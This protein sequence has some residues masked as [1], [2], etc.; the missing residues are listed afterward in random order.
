MRTARGVG[1]CGRHMGVPCSMRIFTSSFS[2]MAPPGWG[3][4]LVGGSFAGAFALELGSV[5]VAMVRE[6][7]ICGPDGVEFACLGSLES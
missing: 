5:F 7:T 2:V 4:L 6:L 1:A 3:L